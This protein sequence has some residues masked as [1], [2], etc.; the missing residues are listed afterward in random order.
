VV[1]EDDGVLSFEWIC[2][3]T[4]IVIGI[5]GG[6]AGARDAVVDELGDSAQAMVALDQSFV[7]PAPLAQTV[8]V[9]IFGSSSAVTGGTP[10]SSFVDFA[11]FEDCTRGNFGVQGQAAEVD[12][13]S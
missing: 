12:S 5:V 1:Q 3:L 2:L 4:L 8:T 13:D 10:G 6:V 9:T 7:W 11:N